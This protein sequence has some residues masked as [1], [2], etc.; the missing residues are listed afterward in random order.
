[1]LSAFDLVREMDAVRRDFDRILRSVGID[2][3]IAPLQRSAFLPA[4][5]ARSYPLLNV[6]EDEKNVYVDALAPGME[7]E[8]LSLNVVRNQLNLSGEKLA[9]DTTLDRSAYHRNERATARFV[10]TVTLPADVDPDH[11]SARFQ[12]GIMRI[13]LPKAESAKPRQIPVKVG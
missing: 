2:G 4:R 1:M 8:S 10:R 9:I 5:G 11:A 13:T 7:P 12:N 3:G 6:S